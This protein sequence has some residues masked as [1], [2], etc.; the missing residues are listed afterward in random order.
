MSTAHI[1]DHM[2]NVLKGWPA[3]F[4]LDKAADLSSDET[5][6]IQQGMVMYLDANGHFRLG[7]ACGKIPHLA[8]RGTA[9]VDTRQSEGN[10]MGGTLS[11]IVCLGPYEVQTTEYDSDQAYAPNDALTAVNTGANIGLVTRGTV[12]EDTILGWVSDGV[13]TGLYEQSILTF[14]TDFVHPLTC[15]SS[16]AA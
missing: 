12:Y 15:A 13:V 14:W 11:G 16:P 2:L 6:A 4:A 3:P 9:F 5:N 8:V 7:L 10:M 1:Y